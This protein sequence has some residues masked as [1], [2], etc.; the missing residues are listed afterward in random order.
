MS[1]RFTIRRATPDDIGVLVELRDAMLS[2]AAE[3]G[4]LRD[5]SEAL[6][7]TREYFEEKLPAGEYV[8]FLAEVEGQVVGLGG[9]VLFRKPPLPQSPL[10]LE[11]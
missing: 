10:G 4:V 3:D 9:M 5:V 6:G 1:E 7:N 11:G 8:C 2:E